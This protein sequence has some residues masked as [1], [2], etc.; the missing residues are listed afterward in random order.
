[1]MTCV[2]ATET[3]RPFPGRGALLS[4]AAGPSSLSCQK[5]G[6]PPAETPRGR[7]AAERAVGIAPAF[8]MQCGQ[9]RE[10]R[11]FHFLAQRVSLIASRDSASAIQSASRFTA[12]PPSPLPPYLGGD[13]VA[14]VQPR[15][16][17]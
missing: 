12:I 16:D 9:H 14:L 7:A 8:S 5:R 13:C 6:P 15:L 2:V 1:M 11:S 10:V 4:R 17:V 3:P